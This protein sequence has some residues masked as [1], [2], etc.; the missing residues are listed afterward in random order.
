[1]QSIR[2][3]VRYIAF[4]A[5]IFTAPSAIVLAIV[6]LV[7]GSIFSD[8]YPWQVF[9]WLTLGLVIAWG[10]MLMPTSLVVN[11]SFKSLLKYETCP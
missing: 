3:N 8:Y 4:D 6:M 1:M 10:L 2:N 11:R 5:L 9:G 7:A